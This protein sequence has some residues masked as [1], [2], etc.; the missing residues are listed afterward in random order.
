MCS[1]RLLDAKRSITKMAAQLKLY[2]NSWHRNMS[3]PHNYALCTPL[4]PSP[5]TF[6]LMNR[7][8]RTRFDVANCL[9]SYYLYFS[10][11]LSHCTPILLLLRLINGKNDHKRHADST[12]R[13]NVD[14]M[15]VCVYVLRTDR[16]IFPIPTIAHRYFNT[17]D[18]NLDARLTFWRAKDVSNAERCGSMCPCWLLGAKRSISNMAMKLMI[19]TD[20]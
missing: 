7:C 19:Y 4:P 17:P 16:L 6:S 5:F 12:L 18:M 8:Y 13:D 15:C 9:A 10:L 11:W 20:S 14:C 2:T 3:R 1:W